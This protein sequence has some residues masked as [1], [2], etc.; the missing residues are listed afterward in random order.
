MNYNPVKKQVFC[1]QCNRWRS[2]HDGVLVLDNQVFCLYHTEELLGY[3]WDV[4][5]VFEICKP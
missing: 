5:E 3:T 1:P 4:P 2:I